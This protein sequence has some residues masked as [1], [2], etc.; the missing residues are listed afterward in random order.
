M[1][2]WL[3]IICRPYIP[4]IGPLFTLHKYL[5]MR[6]QGCLSHMNMNWVTT[7]YRNRFGPQSRRKLCGLQAIYIVRNAIAI[8]LSHR[9]EGGG[10]KQ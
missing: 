5:L 8:H 7:Q 10:Q 2:G 4:D 1:E 9:Y 3:V 6:R